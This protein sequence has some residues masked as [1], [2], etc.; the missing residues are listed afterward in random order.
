MT[1]AL[2]GVV[3][4]GG[5]SS[6]MGTDKA[7][8]EMEDGG[9]LLLL[10]ALRLA[11]VADPVMLASGSAGRLEAFGYPEVGDEV[12]GAGP[13]A[14]IAA[15][16]AA[17]PHELTAV[18]AVDMPLA[19]PSVLRLLA[20][21]ARGED[22]VVPVSSSGL[23]PLHAVYARTALPRLETALRG[24]HLSVREA[25]RGLRVREVRRDEWP[26][27]D[28]SGRFAMNV[29]RPDDLPARNVSRAPGDRRAPSI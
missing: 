13:L 8:L 27:A 25:L 1:G 23:E 19:S 2:A 9:P 6:R 10:V 7:L 5:Q 11:E 17:S 16:L 26:P 18:V 29:N 24:G 14:G 28:P 22:A 3:L 20:S 4:C 12:P 15:G 21:L